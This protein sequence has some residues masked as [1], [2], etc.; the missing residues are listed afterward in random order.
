ML[1]IDPRREANVDRVSIASQKVIV[2][3]DLHAI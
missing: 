3:F 1:I 2:L